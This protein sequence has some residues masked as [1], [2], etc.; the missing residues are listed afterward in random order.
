MR[1]HATPLMSF[2][3]LLL[4]LRTLLPTTLL[5]FRSSHARRFRFRRLHFGGGHGKVRVVDRKPRNRAIT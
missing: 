4:L 5:P 3:L 2:W 1:N